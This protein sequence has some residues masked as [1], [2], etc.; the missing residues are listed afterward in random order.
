MKAIIVN[1]GHTLHGDV[2]V[3]GSKNAALPILFASLVTR[4]TS[5]IK[6]LADIGDVGCAIRIIEALG[7]RVRRRGSELFINTEELHYEKPC[8]EQ[9]RSIRASTYLIGSCL[10]RFGICHLQHFGGCNFSARPIDY[11]LRI[12]E[13]MGA[14]VDEELLRCDG[15][16]SAIIRLPKPSVGAT[17]NALIMT[18]A[19]VGTSVI[20][21]M[22]KEPHILSLI[23]FLRSAGA[24]IT[25]D[26]EK[27]TVSGGA[28]HGGE[29]SLIGDMIEAG[30]YI[31]AGV[32]AGG[33]I[34]VGG[35]DTSELFPFLDILTASGVALDISPDSVRVS[36]EISKPVDVVCAPFPA[37]P[38]DLQPIIAA[39]CAVR[40]GGRIRDTVFPERFG[41][42]SSLSCFGARY[43]LT[44]DTAYIYKP[45]AVISA[46]A[47]APDLRGG[48]A[49]VIA[50][51]A[52]K[53]QSIIGGMEIIERGYEKI[54]RKLRALGA[55]VRASRL[56]LNRF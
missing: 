35:F 26:D 20:Y 21:G 55:D 13:L 48:A 11:H 15:L 1:G 17:V 51:L 39:M 46:T 31:A 16:H 53:G 4:G 9:V 47:V 22:A 12:A 52:A 40:C 8:E 33:D 36:G 32:A 44:R 29:V 54:S 28:L 45:T 38:T 24:D 49:L 19:T 41:Y 30:T 42:L 6:N 23:A 25:V 56:K 3:G 10:S 37:F 2:I 50:A 18:S 27:I 7:A 34:T 14:S 43:R 5:I